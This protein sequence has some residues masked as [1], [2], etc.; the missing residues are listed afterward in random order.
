MPLFFIWFFGAIASAFAGWRLWRRLRYFLHIFQL[1]GYKD[2]EYAHWLKRRWPEAGFRLSH[3]V[4]LGA[5]GAAALGL[6]RVLSP[7]ASALI[8][9]P[10]WCVAFG[11]SK[12]YRSHKPK[13]ALK[14]TNRMKRLVGTAV[15]LALA[16]ILLGATGLVR[17]GVRGMF[18]YLLGFFVADF[19][20]PVWVGVA[21]RINKPLENRFQ[22]GFKQKA[23]EKIAQRPN[24][25]I[26]GITGSYG[27][28][29]VKFI[30]AE[31]LRQRY[32]VLASPGS[33]NTPMGLSLVANEKLKPEHQVLVAEMGMRYPGDIKELCEIMQPDI[34]VET[35]VGVAH[36]ETMGSIDAI[37]QEKGSLIT[38]SKPGAAVV[39]NGDDPRVARMDRLA[40]G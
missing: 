27:K 22:E 36:L 21:G 20:A 3:K 5:L 33:Y 15:A 1:E 11:S 30:L 8:A 37:E 24:L 10:A 32:N 35:S 4:G 17:R 25:T 2:N 18:G 28:T 38:Y 7:V 9:L 29:S 39:L 34:A 40:T 12:Y 19:L 13:K 31:I 6:F 14:Y 16:P 26:V 23:R